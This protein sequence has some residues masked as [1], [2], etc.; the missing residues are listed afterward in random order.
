MAGGNV[1]AA[2][3]STLPLRGRVGAQ[4][5]GGVT[6]RDTQWIAP[7]RSFA[8]TSR[9]KGEATRDRGGYSTK[10]SKPSCSANTIANHR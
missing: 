5:L 1:F 4:R 2:G 8:A 10:R 3:L 9:L 6:C 7:T